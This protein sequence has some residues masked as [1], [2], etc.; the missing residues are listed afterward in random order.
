MNVRIKL[1]SNAVPPYYATAGAAG[2]DLHLYTDMPIIFRPGD[3]RL[4]RTGVHFEIPIGCVGTIRPRSGLATKQGIECLLGT[5]D[6]D[7]RG[8]VHVLLYH[9]GTQTT[10]L[11]HGDR[12]AQI[13]IEPV[14]RCTWD[15]V[16]ELSDTTR[17]DRGFG[18]SGV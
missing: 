2:A 3:R 6:S 10:M 1:A 17:G 5:I 9:Q 11:Y 12:I 8:E 7:Y 18:S 4:F 14:C 16:T 15:I 13:V